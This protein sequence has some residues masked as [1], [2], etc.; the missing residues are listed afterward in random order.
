MRTVA[1]IQAD[2]DAAQATL[3]EYDVFCQKKEAELRLAAR[4]YDKAALQADLQSR[5]VEELQVELSEA[6]VTP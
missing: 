4:W 1:E 3:F 6:K 5:R 2:L